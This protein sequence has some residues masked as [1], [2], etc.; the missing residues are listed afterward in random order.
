MR[1]I[2][3]NGDIKIIKK[4]VELLNRKAPLPL[5]SDG[6]AKWGTNGQMLVTDGTGSTNW[7]TPPAAQVQSDWNE[8]DN[9]KPDFIKNKPSDA[10]QSTSGFM[11]SSDKT[12]LDGIQSGADAVSWTQITNTGTKIAEID[13]NGTS[14]DVYAPT[15]GGSGG[16]TI[17]DADGTDLTAR[18]TL[19][20][21]GYL[22]ADDDSVNSKTVV[23]DTPT[24]VQWSTW[25]TMTDAQK[26]GTKWIIKGV[27]K[28][29][30]TP[31]SNSVSV[32]S[33][34]V[35]TYGQIIAD[36]D[37]LADKDKLTPNSYIVFSSLV[38]RIQEKKAGEN[39]FTSDCQYLQ[40]RKYSQTIQLDEHKFFVFDILN[41]SITGYDFTNTV[42]SSG[43]EATL[44][45]NLIASVG[46]DNSWKKVAYSTPQSLTA[47]SYV[48]VTLSATPN[49]SSYNEVMFALCDH[50]TPGNSDTIE[51]T[52]IAPVGVVGTMLASFSDYG[53]SAIL[54]FGGD[55]T[56]LSKAFIKINQTYANNTFYVEVYAR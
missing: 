52:T 6:N 11:S 19:Q 36:L 2:T 39:R 55:K 25:L 3:Y 41:G 29:G 8:A 4:I 37:A 56:T 51:S 31:T 23:D 30:G 40:N 24:E 49:L 5:D 18:S 21:A 20:F 38:H 16:H 33:D 48:Q 42:P 35:K 14:T 32:I 28:N 46:V 44:Y 13:I 7:V 54:Q 1:K 22:K 34:G 47:G 53:S 12:K 43:F 27:P 26:A 45:Y 9:T 17:Q 50:Y 10:T 15:G